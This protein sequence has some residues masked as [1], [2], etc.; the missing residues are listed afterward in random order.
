MY[1]H[2]GT[3]YIEASEAVEGLANSTA[4]TLT[5]DEPKFRIAS[6]T[7]EGSNGDRDSFGNSGEKSFIIHRAAWRIDPSILYPRR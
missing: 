1:T 6:E 2:S 7:V 4:R 5:I 3:S